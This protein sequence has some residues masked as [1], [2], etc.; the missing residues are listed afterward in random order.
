MKPSV[1]KGEEGE[2]G[3]GKGEMAWISVAFELNPLEH[4]PNAQLNMRPTAS[5]SWVV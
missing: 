5:K 1:H 2:G 4:Q 3:M